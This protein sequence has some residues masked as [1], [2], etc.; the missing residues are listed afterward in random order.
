MTIYEQKT[1]LST[2]SFAHYWQ[3]AEWHVDQRTASKNFLVNLEIEEPPG[4][5]SN[6]AAPLQTR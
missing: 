6:K 1:R 2:W 5:G 4:E 3:P